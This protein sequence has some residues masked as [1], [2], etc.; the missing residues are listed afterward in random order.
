MTERVRRIED[1]TY[2][3]AATTL[4]AAELETLKRRLLPQA[5]EEV[6]NAVES[7][8]CVVAAKCSC[9]DCLAVIDRA[10]ANLSEWRELLTRKAGE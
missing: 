4:A 3:R 2:P 6:A 5:A 7:A 10:L 8:R 1:G 9:L